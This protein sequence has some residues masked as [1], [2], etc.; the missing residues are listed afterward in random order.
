MV[1]FRGGGIGVCLLAESLAT[2]ASAQGT[3]PDT[4]GLS[5]D[6][7]SSITSVPR[8]EQKPSEV[9]SGVC[10][11]TNLNTRPSSLD[12]LAVLMRTVPGHVAGRVDGSKCAI[13]SECLADGM[14][15]LLD[16][17]T[18]FASPTSVVNWDVHG[19][20]LEDIDRLEVIRAPSATRWGRKAVS[21]VV[22]MT[23]KKAIDTVQR[24]PAEVERLEPKVA[25]AQARL[26]IPCGEVVR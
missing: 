11:N 26:E 12:N 22:N 8:T 21:G 10:I 17:R 14:L 13:I 16:V 24:V 7:L 3:K 23:N 15:H 2:L 25:A 6:S 18:L 5:S 20:S 9:V 19:T 4:S 1:V